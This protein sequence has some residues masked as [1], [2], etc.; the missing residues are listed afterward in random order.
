MKIVYFTLITTILISC[1]NTKHEN[2]K[3]KEDLSNN[4]PQQKTN[5]PLN[6]TDSEFYYDFMNQNIFGGE[7]ESEWCKL[8]AQILKHDSDWINHIKSLDSL[9]TESEMNFMINQ[10]DTTNREWECQKIKKVH[11][12]SKSTLDSIFS[13]GT[14]VVEENGEKKVID[15]WEIFREKYGFGGIHSYSMPIYN[16]QKTVLLIKHGGQGDWLIGSGEIYIYKKVNNNWEYVDEISL[17]IS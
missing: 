4:I 6:Q 15:A 16:E 7:K 11:C 17:W 5:S 13:I 3:E 10:I 12:F 14:S 9:L 8:E 1:S 2:Q